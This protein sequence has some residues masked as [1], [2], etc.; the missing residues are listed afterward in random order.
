VVKDELVN[1]DLEKEMEIVRDVVEAAKNARQKGHRKLR[2]P[3]KRIIVSPEDEITFK[4][5]NELSEIIR[6]EV[7]AK[8]MVLLGVGEKWGELKIEISPIYSKIGPKFK[9]KAKD[10]VNA[11]EEVDPR[12]VR[13]S[14]GYEILG[15][16][17]TEDMIDF[18]EKVPDGVFITNFGRGV[19]YV[20]TELTE[21]IESESFAREIIRRVQDMRKEMNLEVTEEIDVRA[22][23]E[24]ERVVKLLKRWNEFISNETR[25]RELKIGTEIKMEGYV[26]EWVVEGMNVRLSVSKIL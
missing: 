12:I 25:A 7:N 18:R 15:E 24:D 6:E 17:I 23:I 16:L 13:G 21:E 1:K 4:A 26:K 19:V 9:K 2:W 3:V 11:L 8:R 14:N 10:I 5:V 20:D 22:T